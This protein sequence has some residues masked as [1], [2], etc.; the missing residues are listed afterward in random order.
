[1]SGSITRTSEPVLVEVAED[2]KCYAG[3]DPS[4][5][6]DELKFIFNEI[7]NFDTYR[8]S[9]ASIVDEGVI[10][11]V[12]ANVGLFAIYAKRQKPKAKLIAFEPIP[13][14]VAALRRNIDLH[15]LTNVTVYPLALGALNQKNVDFCYFPSMPGNSTRHPEIKNA[16]LAAQA[17]N[18]RADVVTISSILP[19]HPEL[20]CIDL[21][22]IDV[23][24][25][26]LEVLAGLTEND[27]EKIQS[28]V[29]E[30][31]DVDD[32]VGALCR[33][34]ENHGYAVVANPD[35][36]IMAEPMYMVH[37]SRKGFDA[38]QSMSL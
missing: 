21:I 15:G 22:K 17:V 3:P 37:A 32:Q 25:S 24:G 26:E 6:Y 16:S 1:M 11:D 14:S 13:A 2:F 4:H 20:D 34:L 38:V 36:K 33:T 10:L 31:K 23:E 7:F 12:G 28:L 27:W 29:I 9:V 8:H 19:R 5:R 35:P 30:I 18:V